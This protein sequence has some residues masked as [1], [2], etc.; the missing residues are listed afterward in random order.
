MIWPFSVF[1]FVCLFVFLAF[2][3]FSIIQLYCP[4]W[5]FSHGKF[6]SLFP[7]KASA[8]ESRYP[9]Y[10]ARWVFRCFHNPPNSA[11]HHRVFIVC[12]DVNACDWPHGGVRTHVRESALKVDSGMKKFFAAPGNRTCVGGVSVLRSTNW[13]TCP[14]PFCLFL[15]ILI[16]VNY[17]GRDCFRSG[18]PGDVPCYQ[19]CNSEAVYLKWAPHPIESDYA[20]WLALA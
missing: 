2:S 8:T 1:V 14:P 9:S 10:G 4:I 16:L 20:A 12:T 7:G 19:T 15:C 5:D 3:I 17:A 13:A 18:R 6:G 11:M